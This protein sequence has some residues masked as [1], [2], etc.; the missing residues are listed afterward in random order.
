MAGRLRQ[1]YSNT[2]NRTNNI[3]QS[4]EVHIPINYSN[5]Q[6]PIENYEN[7]YSIRTF[8]F[9]TAYSIK[10]H[11]ETRSI[12]D[13][14]QT[15]HLINGNTIEKYLQKGYNYIHIG[16]VQVAVKPLVHLGVHAPIYLALR[17]K[18]L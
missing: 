5:W 18:K 11:E 10:T 7:I 17:D 13:E 3:I 2:F 8:D 4:N 6:I 12:Q 15:I 16:L 14:F 1:W 9:K